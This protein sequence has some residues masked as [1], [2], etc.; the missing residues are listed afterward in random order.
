[1]DLGNVSHRRY[2]PLLDEWVLC[3]PGRLKRP[4]LGEREEVSVPVL[5]P[6]DPDCYLC[7]GNRRAG[8]G[9][10]PDY[11]GVFLFDNDYPAL[12]E[13][14]VP[15]GVESHP[16][17]LAASERGFCRVISFSERH[18][19]HLGSLTQAQ[20]E[21]VVDAWGAESERLATEAN[22]AYVQIFENRGATMGASNPHPHG[23]IW[24][25]AHVPTIP[26]R[27][28]E[29]LRSY[30]RDG[31]G[32]LLGDYIDEELRRRERVVD[33]TDSW[34]QLVP[35]WAVWPFE[36]M[37]VPKRLVGSLAELTSVERSELARLLGRT[38]RR[39][40]EVFAVPF[41]YSMGWYQRPGDGGDHRGFRLHAVYLP[42][43]LRSASVRKFVVGYELTAEPQRD[44]TA[45]EAAERLR[46]I[47]P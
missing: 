45:E 34:V 13:D 2:N 1:M 37:L 40:D 26:R 8:G 25:V 18:D 29:R 43:L 35:F 46:A 7:P 42:P 27:K 6:Y 12:T 33:E 38:V 31:R 11:R 30:R 28:A 4:W 16:L 5:P 10:N 24:A 23:Q 22:A 9:S 21:A 32:D 15:L 39:Y 36:T 20:V 47:L 41:P 44:F 19:L 14:A 17:F 3:S